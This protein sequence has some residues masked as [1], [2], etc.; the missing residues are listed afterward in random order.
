MV[1]TGL[2]LYLLPATS[3]KFGID[4]CGRDRVICRCHLRYQWPRFPL[5]FSRAL[6][7]TNIITDRNQWL[8]PKK[9]LMWRSARGFCRREECQE[10]QGLV[11]A[12]LQLK[13]E[14]E[15]ATSGGE[16]HPLS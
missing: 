2:Y 15:T 10:Q 1:K 13:V 14:A 4:R 12:R 7:C 16:N 5:C 9:F 8:A 6:Y 3:E 11:G